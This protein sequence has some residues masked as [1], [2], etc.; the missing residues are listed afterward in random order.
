[1]QKEK[2]PLFEIK[3]NR[4]SKKHK[5]VNEKEYIK[6]NTKENKRN[7]RKHNVQLYNKFEIW[8]LHDLLANNMCNNPSKERK[9]E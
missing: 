8:N 4:E 6:T 2:P 9:L 1:M 7:K 5:I 3:E